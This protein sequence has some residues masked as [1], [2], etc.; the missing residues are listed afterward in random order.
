M[1]LPGEDTSV[2]STWLRPPLLSSF[3]ILQ[4]AAV[5]FELLGGA[6]GGSTVLVA[7]WAGAKRFGVLSPVDLLAPSSSPV[8]LEAQELKVLRTQSC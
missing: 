7:S 4:L 6:H 8:P 1:H 3:A 5:R 2:L